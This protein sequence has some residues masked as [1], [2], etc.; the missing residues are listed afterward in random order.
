V[1]V[2]AFGLVGAT[3]WSGAVADVFSGPGPIAIPD[4]GPGS[5]FPSTIAVPVGGVVTDVNVTL[6]DVTHTNPFHLWVLLQGP[7]GQHVVLVSG[8]GGDLD[9]AGVDLTIDD[10]APAAFPPTAV[11]TSGSYR[12]TDGYPPFRPSPA[13][14]PPHAPTLSVFDGT[15]AGGTWR[16]FPADYAV[17]HSGSIG[18]WRLDLTLATVSPSP[19]AGR[20]GD[21]IVLTG[22]GFTGAT[23]VRFGGALAATFSV[24]SDARITT[25]VP[26]QA[27][28]GPVEVVVPAGTITSSVDFV[29]HHARRVTL[30]LNGERGVGRVSVSDGFS[31]CAANVPVR[32]QH[33]SR[34]RWTAVAGILTKPNGS[35]RAVGLDDGGRY[36]AVAKRAKL[37]SGDVC[38]PD[39]SR[40]VAT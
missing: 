36:R 18:G 31:P 26:E 20:V 28:A 24:D 13:P 6:T 17:G 14:D 7:A 21:Q 5:P 11:L 37:P 29:V 2:L 34:N 38:L 19:M 33:R 27:V 30:R 32:V 39:V 3:P 12:P 15:S 22:S 10:E 16:L 4:V 25:L 1:L 9:I 40:V 8:S 23:A 35:F